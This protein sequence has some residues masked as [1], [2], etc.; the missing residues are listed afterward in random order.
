MSK[1]LVDDL[2]YKGYE[3]YISK[4]SEGYYSGDAHYNGELSFSVTGFED[5]D[6]VESRAMDMIDKINRF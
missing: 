4:E 6:E 1:I 5:V 2:I 3:I